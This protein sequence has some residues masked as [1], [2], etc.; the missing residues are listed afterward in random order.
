MASR[1]LRPV[2]AGG[3]RVRFN[4]MTVGQRSMGKSTFLKSMLRDYVSDFDI[5]KPPA[6]QKD[7]RILSPHYSEA[8]TVRVVEVGRAEVN[9]V[10]LVMYDGQGYGDFINNQDAVDTIRNHLIKQHASWR[11]LDIQVVTILFELI[12]TASICFSG[13]R[14]LRF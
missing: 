9:S 2:D 13:N 12:A 8:D 14:P 4:I 10:D 5:E 7:T 1:V 6:M 3:H 11:N